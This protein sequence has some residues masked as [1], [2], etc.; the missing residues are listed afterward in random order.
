LQIKYSILERFLL[1]LL[2]NIL[3][4]LKLF[5]NNLTIEK[6]L[7]ALFD[8]IV[9]LFLLASCIIYFF[10]PLY[11]KEKF[12]IE[13]I[14]IYYNDKNFVENKSFYKPLQKSIKKIKSDLIYDSKI[15]VDI[16]FV[17]NRFVFELLTFFHDYIAINF[18]DKIFIDKQY[19]YDESKNTS[20]AYSE[21]VHEVIHSL[22][23]KRYGGWIRTSIIMPYWVR[24]GYAVYSSRL[25]KFDSDTVEFISGIQDM[26]LDSMSEN[27]K[28]IIYGLMVK[29]AIE[30]MH[31]SVDDLHL[32]K[33]DY[34]EV[35]DSMLREYNISK[36]PSP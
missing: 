15:H 35:L 26:Y 33:V 9:L 36:T 28:Y 7:L 27:K 13:N 23:A 14:S 6:K 31:K 25:L 12:N 29:H 1:P 5:N 32:G 34:D 20:L 16:F 19:V 11:Y 22:Q 17:D 18:Y 21:I 30:K 2:Y 4:F 24:E 3:P 8:T 10:S